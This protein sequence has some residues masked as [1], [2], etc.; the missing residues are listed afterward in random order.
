MQLL[1]GR[2]L[3]LKEYNEMK[4]CIMWLGGIEWGLNW[5]EHMVSARLE[6]EISGSEAEGE[7][8]GENNF[9]RYDVLAFYIGRGSSG[10][11]YLARSFLAL[12]PRL[13]VLLDQNFFLHM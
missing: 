4:T 1:R 7:I 6:I 2:A 11:F 10:F 13:M 5:D 8:E 9:L 3:E 12:R